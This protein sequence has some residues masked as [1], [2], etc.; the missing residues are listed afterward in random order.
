MRNK[1]NKTKIIENEKEFYKMVS[2]NKIEMGRPV[3]LDDNRIRVVYN[4]KD[5]Y[6]IEHKTSNVIVS[7]WTTR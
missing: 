3:M 1:L 6:L 2:N 4:D 7:L 5:E